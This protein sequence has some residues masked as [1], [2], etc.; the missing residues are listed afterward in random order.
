MSGMLNTLL[1]INQI[2]S[3]TVSV[4]RASFPINEL[5]D[6]LRDEFSYHAQ[7]HKLAFRVVPCGLSVNSDIRLL[8][9]MLRNLVSNALKYT[10]H[11]KVLLGCRRHAG[12][13][14]IEVCDTGPGIPEGE[15]QAI[16]EEYH[17]LDN[18][19]RER[20]RG[21]GLGLSIVSGLGKLLG[22]RVR[23]RSRTGKGSIFAVDVPLASSDSATAP[24]HA[25]LA[26]T[27]KTH[28][29]A[30]HRNR[31]ILIVDDDPDVR[32]LLELYLNGEG[33]RTATAPDGVA[34]LALATR[35]TIRPDL[36]LADYN[37]PNGMDGLQ[38]AAKLRD[39][40]HR[41]VPVIIL[42]G[43]IST[44]TLARHCSL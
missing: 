43:D 36:I 33:H 28:S 30:R 24:K 7:A 19:A 40:L 35:G 18:A 4:N 31:T 8:E 38:V 39:A 15:F 17:Q 42:T 1:D 14:T 5:L 25:E 37:L 16:F 34:A 29:S 21:L 20:S 13:L 27:D 22:H 32:E 44:D 10:K 9:Q 23:V 11:G 41:E 26:L 12:M 2:D 6:R 3:G